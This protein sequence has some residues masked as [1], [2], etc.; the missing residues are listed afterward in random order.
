MIQS[1]SPLLQGPSTISPATGSIRAWR[2]A[3]IAV[4]VKNF[5]RL[6][7]AD[8]RLRIYFMNNH[9]SGR[10]RDLAA[11]LTA[12][13]DAPS[14]ELQVAFAAALP[15]ATLKSEDRDLVGHY[16]LTALLQQRL[17]PDLLIAAAKLLTETRREPARL[18]DILSFV[19]VYPSHMARHGL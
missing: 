13:L 11:A 10:R 7:L 4:A 12:S 19:N 16:L 1:T 2:P 17:G 18:P 6:A 15:L 9:L 5:Y 14:A 3:A 8:P